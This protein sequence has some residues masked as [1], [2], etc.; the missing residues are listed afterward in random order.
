MLPRSEISALGARLRLLILQ[1]EHLT[2]CA[3]C[4][5]VDLLDQS[6]LASLF[7]SQVPALPAL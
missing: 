6:L 2:M 5:T 7:S 3:T 4:T 1:I